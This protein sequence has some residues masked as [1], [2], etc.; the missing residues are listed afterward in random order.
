MCG[1]PL[2][3]GPHVGESRRPDL[4]GTPVYGLVVRFDLHPGLEDGFDELVAATVEG[5]NAL[6]PGTLI[7]ATHTVE[8]EPSTRIFYELYR[9]FAA[10]EEHERQPHTRHFLANRGKY[11]KTARVERLALGA[12]KGTDKP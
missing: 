3:C 10:F 9:D 7:Y 12:S 4:K 8:G 2:G 11:I 1:S 5:I 6:E